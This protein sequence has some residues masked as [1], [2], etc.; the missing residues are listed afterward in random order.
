MFINY[1]SGT[2]FCF[3]LLAYP[4]SLSL[5]LT[6]TKPK[7]CLLSKCFKICNFAIRV[8]KSNTYF[9]VGYFENNP[10]DWME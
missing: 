1:I 5:F 7:N 8:L 6:L 10:I 9:N 2:A 3:F 4:P